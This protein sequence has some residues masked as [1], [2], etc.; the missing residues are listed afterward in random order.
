MENTVRLTDDELIAIASKAVRDFF[1]EDVVETSHIEIRYSSHALAT[2]EQAEGGV[3]PSIWLV[4]ETG[5]RNF[6]PVDIARANQR[7][8]IMLRERG[9]QRL[10]SLSHGFQSDPTATKRAA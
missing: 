3:L 5:N 6:S 9:D 2:T 7:I 4:H 1:S 10:L 8:W